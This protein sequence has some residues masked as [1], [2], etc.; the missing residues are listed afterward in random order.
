MSKALLAIRTSFVVLDLCYYSSAIPLPCSMLD[1]EAVRQL[2]ALGADPNVGPPNGALAAVPV[3]AVAA[4][5]WGQASAGT[6][7][8]AGTAAGTAAGAAA[9]NPAASQIMEM[10]LAAGADCLGVPGGQPGGMSLLARYAGADL[11][12]PSSGYH[13]A[14]DVML[15]HLE[16]QRAAGALELSGHEQASQLLL[17][18]ALRGHQPLFSNAL[19]SL[20]RTLGGQPLGY[21]ASHSLTAVL[22]ALAR[23]ASAAS[24]LHQLLHSTLALDLA[25]RDGSGRTL[26]AVAAASP[27]AATTVPMLHTAGARLTGDALME[28]VQELAPAAVKALLA[29]GR[30]AFDTSKP[31]LVVLGKHGF[32]CVIHCALNAA[33]RLLQVELFTRLGRHGGHTT[34][35]HSK[36]SSAESPHRIWSAHAPLTCPLFTSTAG[37]ARQP[38]RQGG[39]ASSGSVCHAC[40][41]RA[42]GCWLPA[43][44]VRGC[45]RPAVGGAGV[46]RGAAAPRPL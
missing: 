3:I 10:L 6:A 36:V 37:P 40:G 8:T 24:P 11:D 45:G 15:A 21:H 30:P 22:L 23:S 13:Q 35:I 26:L 46:A 31:D 12:L 16:Q 25:A 38:G 32:S 42:A 19:D 41:G 33:N 27:A 29:C 14:A 4:S 28:H 18:A 17:A 9:A 39:G 34:C 2:L 1:V 44:S 7:G 20:E 43:H 5:G